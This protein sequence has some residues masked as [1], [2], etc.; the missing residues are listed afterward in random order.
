[1]KPWAGTALAA[2]LLSPWAQA[3]ESPLALFASGQF[4]QAEAAGASQDDA[5]GLALAARAVLADEMMRDTP[6]L[7][8]LKRAE[9]LSRRAIAADPKQ[10]E[11]HI[12][13]AVA[14]GYETRIIGDLAAQSK[15]Y[16]GET[17][18]HLEAALASNPDDPWALAA[19]GSWHIEIVRSAGPTLAHWLFGADFA[20]GESDYAK[21]FAVAPTN[22]VL[23]YQHALTIAAF[24]LPAYRRSVES[25][26]AK[27]A[28][29]APASAYELFVRERAKELLEMLNRGN[30][31]EIQKLVRRDR[32]YPA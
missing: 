1:M 6:C 29:G 30:E 3:S 11:G 25:D 24:D 17:R 7:E 32:G 27:A 12:Y 20:T 8:C 23:R 22:P 19:M 31:A 16:A 26:L 28:A 14:I 13:L 10:A 5:Q 18:K 15:G 9:S 21:A 4:A 2:F